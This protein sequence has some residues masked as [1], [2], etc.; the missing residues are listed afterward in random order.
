[1]KKVI[2]VIPLKFSVE[3]QI[4]MRALGA[5]IINTPREDGMLGAEKKAEE[6]V[7]TISGAISLQQFKN[8]SNPRAHYETTGRRSIRILTGKSI[9]LSPAP[10]A[11][12]PFPAS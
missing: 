3:K 10:A 1:M 5:E 8:L 11:A 12:G 2:F 4:L 9:T 7:Q 6:L